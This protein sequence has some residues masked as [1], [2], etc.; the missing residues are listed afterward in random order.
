[1]IFPVVAHTSGRSRSRSLTDI[2]AAIAHATGCPCEG[3]RGPELIQKRLRNTY[4]EEILQNYRVDGI[5]FDPDSAQAL[6]EANP[7]DFERWA[8][9][10]VSGQ[11]NEKQVGD[12]GVDGVIRFPLD[13]KSMGRALVSVKGGRQLNPAMVRDLIGTVD[14]H[15]A[16]MGLLITMGSVTRGMT[17]ALNRSGSYIWPVNQ[18]RYPKVQAVTIEKLLSGHKPELPPAVLPYVKARAYAG[19]QSHWGPEPMRSVD[20]DDLRAVRRSGGYGLH[21]GREGQW[22]ERRGGRGSDRCCPRRM[23]ATITAALERVPVG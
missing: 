4:G 5:P 8:V 17:E 21:R 3:L 10:L 18:R 13:N 15:R 2:P 6:F 14:A 22:P 16:E 7:F 1:M 9:S 19:E 11:P 23:D 20:D 12:R